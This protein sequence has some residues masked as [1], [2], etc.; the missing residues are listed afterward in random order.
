MTEPPNVSAFVS[1]KHRKTPDK[2]AYCMEKDKL[3]PD[4]LLAAY[5]RGIF[6]M[7]D[8]EAEDQIYWYAPDPRGIIPIEQFHVP[9]TLAQLVR[10][11]RFEVMNDRNFRAVMRGC[12]DRETTWISEE[13]IDAYTALHERGYAHS[14]ECWQDGQ[15]VG[16]LYGVA[17]KGAFFGESMFYR[18]RDASKVALVHLVRRLHRRGFKLLDTQFV[19]DHLRQ[20]G[21]KEIPR[22]AYEKRL[23]HALCADV[24]W[25][26]S[27]H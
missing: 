16:G 20:F 8:P 15:L 26:G 18:V 10:Q 1:Y 25:G 21:A 5:Q 14:V 4:L 11:E 6:P 22:A 13:I 7:A 24:T 3:T 9:G 2:N 19:T 27:R 12:A 23:A 17:V